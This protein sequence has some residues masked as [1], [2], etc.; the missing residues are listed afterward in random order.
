M[1]ETPI[2]VVGNIVNDPHGR[3]VG[4]QEVIKFRLPATRAAGRPTAPGRPAIRCS[5]RFNCWAGWSL[6]SVRLC[7]RA[8]VIV[9]GHVF[10]SD[11]RIAN[12]NRRSSLEC[13]PHP[14]GRICRGRSCALLRRLAPAGTRRSADEPCRGRIRREGI[15]RRRSCGRRPGRRRK[16]L[17]LSRSLLQRSGRLGRVA[18]PN[19]FRETYEPRKATPRMAELFIRC[20]RSARRTA[21][22][23]S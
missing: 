19:M 11:T 3:R 2:T 9:V 14:L 20:G 18:T 10:T 15:R 6:A 5:S 13:V 7:A 23:H 1:F 12:G 17:P 21:Q 8:P 16:P 22:G 4:D